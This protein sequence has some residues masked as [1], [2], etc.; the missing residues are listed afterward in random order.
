MRCHDPALPKEVRKDTSTYQYV[1]MLSVSVQRR[2]RVM[3][4]YWGNGE[5]DTLSSCG[6][7]L[8]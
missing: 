4:L 1:L 5:T 6:Y 2:D 8:R 7:H 3:L